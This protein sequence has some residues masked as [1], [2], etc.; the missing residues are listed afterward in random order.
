MPL[1]NLFCYLG[2]I[3]NVLNNA[4]IAYSLG[5]LDSPKAWEERERL[6]REVASGNKEISEGLYGGWKM[7]AIRKARKD[8]LEKESAGP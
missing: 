5:G 3:Q 7:V 1:N 8:A 4:H 6:I 2:H